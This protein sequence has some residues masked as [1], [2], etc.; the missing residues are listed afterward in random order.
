MC[1]LLIEW[2]SLA[3]Q[4][5]Q[6]Y[7]CVLLV[8]ICC[9]EVRAWFGL[10]TKLSFLSFLGF[11]CSKFRESSLVAFFQLVGLTFVCHFQSLVE[12]AETELGCLRVRV[13]L[14][15]VVNVD[16]NHFGVRSDCTVLCILFFS[17][18]GPFR[19]RFVL[20]VMLFLYHQIITYLMIRNSDWFSDLRL[21][22]LSFFSPL[23]R[24]ILQYIFRHEKNWSFAWNTRNGLYPCVPFGLG[25]NLLQVIHRLLFKGVLNLHFCL[26]AFG[27][28]L[29][30]VAWCWRN[31]GTS[32]ANVHS[33]RFV[34]RHWLN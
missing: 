34:G 7:F 12:T 4:M 26:R 8:I 9:V 30:V 29:F 21:N 11:H 6:Y 24:I 31:V 10:A 2:L 13:T 15:G 23:V 28:L 5:M 16:G 19:L 22:L 18:C 25:S 3:G 1:L 32:E 27:C 14:V 20:L 17:D 33:L